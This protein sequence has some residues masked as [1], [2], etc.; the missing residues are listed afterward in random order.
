MKTVQYNHNLPRLAKGLA[1][2]AP[3]SEHS[4]NRRGYEFHHLKSPTAG[5]DAYDTDNIVIMTP[6]AHT[7]KH[8]TTY[9][10]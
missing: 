8:K 2:Y 1:P 5:G 7:L 9:K 3:F 4:H 6:K 10:K